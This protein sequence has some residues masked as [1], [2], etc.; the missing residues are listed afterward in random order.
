MRNA[1]E[2]LAIKENIARLQR[3]LEDGTFNGASKPAVAGIRFALREI[4]KDTGLT[5]EELQL[6]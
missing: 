4:L 5:M 2:L 1:E 6:E 3:C